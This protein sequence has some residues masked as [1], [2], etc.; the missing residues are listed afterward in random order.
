[1]LEPQ[2]TMWSAP[3]AERAGRPLLVLLHGHGGRE[4]DL[5]QLS[6]YLPLDRTIAAP[7]GGF[8][9]GDGYTWFD[10][11][12]SRPGPLDAATDEVAVWLRSAGATAS[13]VTLFG[14]SQGGVL[15]LQLLR[16]HPELVDAVVMLSGVVEPDDDDG[17]VRL[18]E[19]R[20]PVFWGRGTSDELVPGSG[21]ERTRDWLLAHTT[22]TER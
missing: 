4:G 9:H 16:R 8:E 15:A 14:F 20:P 22:L 13:S 19:F 18:A 3:V 6:P 10:V 2:H 5:F 1:M 17:D 21:V 11:A 12:A 7:R